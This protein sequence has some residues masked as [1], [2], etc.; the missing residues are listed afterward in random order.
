MN[1]P[2][3]IYSF[4]PWRPVTSKHVFLESVEYGIDSGLF[5]AMEEDGCL[6]TLEFGE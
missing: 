5:T 3:F 1:E 4:P 6:G 2:F